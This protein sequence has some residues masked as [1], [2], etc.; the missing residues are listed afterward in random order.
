LFFKLILQRVEPSKDY[1][2]KVI[3]D[4]TTNIAEV[5]NLSIDDAETIYDKYAEKINEECDVYIGDGDVDYYDAEQCKKIS[6]WLKSNIDKEN[7]KHIRDELNILL[8]YCLRAIDLNTWVVIE[9]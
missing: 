4:D 2:F 1:Y 6:E 7:N 8:N 9:I 3:P 5:H